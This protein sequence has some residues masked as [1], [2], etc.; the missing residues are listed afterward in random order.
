MNF[1]SWVLASFAFCCFVAGAEPQRTNNVSVNLQKYVRFGAEVSL[2]FSDDGRSVCA[3]WPPS[4]VGDVR[5]KPVDFVVFDLEG[6]ILA[7]SKGITNRMGALRGFPQLQCIE[8]CQNLLTNADDWS[9]ASDLSQIVRLMKVDR[10]Q[11]VAEMWDLIAT[12]KVLWERKLP[13]AFGVEL[14]TPIFNAKWD[15]ILV[16]LSG[17]DA[18]VLNRE[19]GAT[20]W[21]RTT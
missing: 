16:A 11:V 17:T 12:P 13:K 20:R 21:L 3:S 1:R 10:D 7:D 15:T 14:A 9:V 5:K 18:I 8:R 19:T 6:N 4:P 2:S